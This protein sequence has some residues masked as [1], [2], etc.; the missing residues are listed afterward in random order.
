MTATPD[1]TD[2][3]AP[4]PR[5]RRR[6]WRTALVSA[7]VVVLVVVGALTGVGV[8]LVNR[9][10]AAIDRVPDVFAGVPDRPAA[11][12]P[13]DPSVDDAPV[14]FLV[15][16]SDTRAD[17]AAGELP[18]AR[19]DV[20][21]LIRLTADRTHAQVVSIPRDSW[22]LVPG[23]GMSKINAAY[24]R[25]GPS[26]LVTT[27]ERLT[28]VRIDHFVTFDFQGFVTITDALG[29]VDVDVAETTT[30]RGYT[31]TAGENHLDGAAALAYVRERTGLPGGDLDRVQ[32]QQ[33]VIQ[34]QFAE[35]RR[36][37][38]FADL[39][40]LSSTV[41]ALTASMAVDDTLSNA[42]LID[43]A[44]SLRGLDSSGIT[45]LTAPVA[46]TGREGAQSVV[47]LDDARCAALW[48][49]LRTDS[50]ADHVDEFAG[51]LLP[52]VPN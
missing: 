51:D 12:V 7:L 32:R 16:G 30:S 2:H 19:S 49:Y 35:L 46:G 43:I 25:G 31:F 48:T 14:T 3:S 40:T 36:R 20:I 26:L 17:I 33:Q 50:L 34:A 24:A 38:V 15:V 47:R 41:S 52:E 29:G 37:D 8:Y 27:V 6:R 23:V 18:D 21:M 13:V 10:G 42:A 9:Y 11:P 28:E 39:G 5:R 1:G 44:W 22:V 45:F 4:A